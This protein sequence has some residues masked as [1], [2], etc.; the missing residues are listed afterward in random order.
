[1]PS[2]I[3]TD[4]GT[5]Q[6]REMLFDHTRITGLFGFE[7][8]KAIFEKVDSRFKF[9][10]LTFKKGGPTEEF[11]A[12]FMR[13]EVTELKNFP[14]EGCLYISP[15]LVRRASPRSLSITEY[16]VQEDLDIARRL[17]TFPLLADIEE[18]WGLELY[19][20]ELYP[21]P[22]DKECL[23]N[24][25]L[26]ILSSSSFMLTTDP[27][28]IQTST[29]SLCHRVHYAS[30]LYTITSKLKLYPAVTQFHCQVCVRLRPGG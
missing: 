13:R 11:P 3:Y 9:V 7:N 29:V 1:M 19:G 28:D 20:E 30:R 23:G 18:G 24:K 8:R 17:Q 22:N 6:L 16:R 2:G 21:M 26:L 14:Q 10:V 5:K 12:A 15:A 25:A 4:L 27:S